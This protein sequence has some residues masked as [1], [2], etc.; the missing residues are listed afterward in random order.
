MIKENLVI[1]ESPA[2]AK[3]I[4]KILGGEYIVKSS[5][6]HIRDLSKHGVH[7]DVEGGFVPDYEISPDKKLVVAELRKLSKE[8]SVVW[9]ASDEDRE[10]E[11]IAWHLEQALNLPKEK[12]R[13]IVF[14][15]ITSSAILGAIK[16]PRS[17]DQALVDAQQARRVLDRLV[18]FELSPLLWKKVKPSL[19]AGRVQSVVVKLIVECEREVLAFQAKQYFRVTGEFLTA[20]GKAVKA[21]VKERFTTMEQAM[22]FLESLKRAAYQVEN[23]Q[24]TPIK[25]TPAPPF[26]TS[27]LQQEASRKLGFS[28]SQTMSV[29]QKL[30][31]EGLITYMR[32]DSYNLSKEAVMA[33]GQVIDSSFGAEYHKSRVFTTKT[34][35]AQEAHEAIRPTDLRRKSIEGPVQ[36]KRLY[37]LIWRRTVATQMADALLERTTITIAT[38]LG[39]NN[40]VAT[41]E[42]IK[43]DGF[44]KLYIE[45]VD[46]DASALGEGDS[47]LPKLSV[48][49]SLSGKIITA[50]ERYTQRPSRYGEAS[51]VKKLEELGIG[52]PSTYAPTISTVITRGYVVKEDRTGVERA[53]SVIT[54]SDG[55][56][57]QVAKTEIT[58][59]E[60]NKLFPT[61]IGMLVTDYLEQHFPDVLDYNFTAKVEKEFDEIADGELEWQK[62]LKAFYGP[63]HSTVLEADSNSDFARSERLLGVDPVSGKNVYARVGRFGPMVQLGESEEVSGEKPK[64]AS[65]QKGQLVASITLD[66]AM[67]LFALPRVVGLYEDKEVVASLGRFGPFVRHD[68]KF[69]SLK[70]EDNPYT[71]TLDRAIE[72]IEAKRLADANKYI[73]IFGDIQVINGRYGAYIGYNGKNYKI[74]K[75]IT[76]PAAL[77]EADCQMLIDKGDAEGTATVQKTAKKAVAKKAPVRKKTATTKTTAAKTAAA[78]KTTTTAVKATTAKATTAKTT[79]AKTATTKVATTKAATVKPA[80][81]TATTKTATKTTATKK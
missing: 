23:L 3:T 56:I 43:F 74:P 65:L 75:T 20:K 25:R 55:K 59:A 67:G 12:T 49:D 1:V 14:H 29:A 47:L 34:K 24:T 10:G 63:F 19:S 46:D 31:E 30:Y 42:V 33:A 11:A 76:E 64:F 53:Y 13:R 60:K 5:F 71:I 54:L 58:G 44:L 79:T 70:K 40:F 52:R 32:T 15:E 35:G 2:K 22:A 38:G 48:G 66:E 39:T 41:G 50:T 61:D 21:E 4:E 78:K 36:Q 37:D 27:T 8:A 28:V 77:T 26:T 18:G 51:L 6:G 9:L 7:V 45:S 16:N 68:S 80:T 73:N 72:L 62:M 81:K 17:I 57:S 69:T